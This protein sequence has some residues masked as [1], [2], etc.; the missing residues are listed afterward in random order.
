MDKALNIGTKSVPPLVPVLRRLLKGE[1]IHHHDIISES[2][3]Q[4]HRL[5]I[6][7]HRLRHKY[8]FNGLVQCPRD[9]NHPLKDHYFILSRDIPKAQEIAVLYGLGGALI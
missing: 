7:V 9:G 6:T 4:Q 2:N 5:G 3:G 1:A 8:G